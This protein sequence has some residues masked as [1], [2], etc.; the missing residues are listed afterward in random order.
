MKQEEQA[1]NGT[2]QERLITTPGLSAIRHLPWPNPQLSKCILE[3]LDASR[4]QY[5]FTQYRT[6]WGKNH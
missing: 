6:Q 4:S 2:S 3:I 1:T 5:V